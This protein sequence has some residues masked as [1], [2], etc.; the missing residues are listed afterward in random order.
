MLL[1]LVRLVAELAAHLDLALGSHDVAHLHPQHQA[2][3]RAVGSG[4]PHSLK[5]CTCLCPSSRGPG[6]PS[7]RAP[8]PSPPPASP[9]HP[10]VVPHPPSAMPP[11][12]SCG[13]GVTLPAGYILRVRVMTSGAQPKPRSARILQTSHNG[14][15]EG[16]RS[17]LGPNLPDRLGNAQVSHYPAN[18]A[19][20]QHEGHLTPRRLKHGPS[21]HSQVAWVPPIHQTAD[22]DHRL[23]K[24]CAARLLL[25]SCVML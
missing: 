19:E 20:P 16:Q 6:L 2:G 14:E 1:E 17:V 13:P 23:T 7:D 15:G 21:K 10:N 9:P 12:S 3:A 18:R 24:T 11:P 25:R 4:K 5:T 8:T 22:A